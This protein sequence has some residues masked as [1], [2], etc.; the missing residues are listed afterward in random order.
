MSY[1][2]PVLAILLWQVFVVPVIA[3]EETIP[4][5]GVVVAIQRGKNDTRIIDPPCLTQSFTEVGLLLE[6]S[7]D[8]EISKSFWKNHLG[9]YRRYSCCWALILDSGWSSVAGCKSI[10]ANASRIHAR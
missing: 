5:D 10:S 9:V 6:S 2:I 1:R 8:H 7:G 3:K 4:V